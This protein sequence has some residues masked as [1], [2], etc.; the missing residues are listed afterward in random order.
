M[1]PVI[2]SQK[3]DVILTSEITD[4]H[5]VVAVI[6]KSPCL[7]SKQY[8]SADKE[9]GYLILDNG[10]IRGNAFSP[11]QKT[12][13]EKVEWAINNAEN[14]AVFHQSDWK[15]ALQWLIDNA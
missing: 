1:K 12:L 11:Y 15:Q 4:S 5:I 6:D 9:L 13:K 2:E 10:F 7:L 14:V 3:Q 8:K